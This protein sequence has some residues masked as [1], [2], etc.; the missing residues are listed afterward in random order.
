MDVEWLNFLSHC[1]FV[2]T[3]AWAGHDGEE[4][5]GSREATSLDG[6][7]CACGH[8]H[9]SSKQHQQVSA[10]VLWQWEWACWV[11]LWSN[12]CA[13]LQHSNGYMCVCVC[14]CVCVCACARTGMSVFAHMVGKC[15]V[16]ECRAKVLHQ[17][18]TNESAE[19]LITSSRL[20]FSLTVML[21]VISQVSNQGILSCYIEG[22]QPGGLLGTRLLALGVWRDGLCGMCQWVLVVTAS[23]SFSLLVLRLPLKHYLCCL[24]V[25]LIFSG[26]MLQT[27]SSLALA[28]PLSRNGKCGSSWQQQVSWSSKPTSNSQ[29]SPAM[30]KKSQRAWLSQGC[31]FTEHLPVIFQ[32]ALAHIVQLK[33]WAGGDRKSVC[34]NRNKLSSL[35]WN[36]P[37]FF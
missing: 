31:M 23:I 9:F 37:T 36:N 5:C 20:D 16:P 25:I 6:P 11:F 15:K 32:T 17:K 18:Q 26:L 28:M 13:L 19:N 3:K 8:S 2:D 29:L 33:Q 34:M 1:C 7:D 21:F 35:K 27:L 14:V 22:N 4:L 10:Q 12:R 30:L 24:P